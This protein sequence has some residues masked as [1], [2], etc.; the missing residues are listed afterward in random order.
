VTSL[1][2]VGL[3]EILPAEVQRSWWPQTVWEPI[4][5]YGVSLN[6]SS[7]WTAGTGAPKLWP[8]SVDLVTM[9]WLSRS[10]STSQA[11][12]FWPFRKCTYRSPL[13]A[14]SGMENWS[15][16]QSVPEPVDWKVQLG[17]EPEIS[18]GVAQ[19]RPPSSE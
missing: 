7:S 8:P 17:W 15:S 11:A 5:E 10:K 18:L 4:T 13:A 16:S 2:L 19:V 12:W 6:P 3:T 14:T 9:I 1:G